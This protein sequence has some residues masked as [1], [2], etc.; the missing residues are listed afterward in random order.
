MT[1]TSRAARSAPPASGAGGLPGPWLVRLL[2]PESTM[3]L[4][5]LLLAMSVL[6]LLFPP[7][8]LADAGGMRAAE[9]AAARHSSLVDPLASAWMH[10]L[11]LLL[12]LQLLLRGWSRRVWPALAPGRPAGRRSGVLAL[13]GLFLAL[14]GGAWDRAHQVD[15]RLELAA[16]ETRE[17]C[18]AQVAGRPVERFLGQQVTLARWDAQLQTGELQLR[19]PGEEAV[20]FAIA[21]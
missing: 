9:L 1:S 17:T 13:T 14:A 21:P 15:G 19:R 8:A 6:A 18:R 12:V 4:A 20:P 2:S 10:L 16:G 11:A 7:A 5:A 3:A